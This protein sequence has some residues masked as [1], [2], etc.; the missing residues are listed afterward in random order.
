MYSSRLMATT[1]E[2]LSFA[3]LSALLCASW[4][5]RSAAGS[6]CNVDNVIPMFIVKLLIAT[7]YNFNNIKARLAVSRSDV[8]CIVLGV[9][10]QGDHEVGEQFCSY[11][12]TCGQFESG[13]FHVGIP[14]VNSTT[15]EPLHDTE[16]E[17][18]LRSL[19]PGVWETTG[20]WMNG[21][22]SVLEIVHTFGHCCSLQLLKTFLY[23]ISRS[24]FSVNDLSQQW[25]RCCK[26]GTW[27]TYVKICPQGPNWDSKSTC[28]CQSHA[29]PST[30][31]WS[32][33][34]SCRPAKIVKSQTHLLSHAFWNLKFGVQSYQN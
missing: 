29:H 21:L 7:I 16:A 33:V 11:R 12:G 22:K 4:S 23:I 18:L 17:A 10:F 3:V 32:L 24:L 19:C 9:L 1:R 27:Q 25:S 2:L 13:G 34:D 30:M 31:D 20:T 8:D 5:M 15:P 6:S 26:I 28:K 14:C